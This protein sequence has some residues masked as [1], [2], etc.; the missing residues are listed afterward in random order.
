VIFLYFDYEDW[1]DLYY[2]EFH[3]GTDVVV[4]GVYHYDEK[5]L[6]VPDED[7][8][9]RK[10]AMNSIHDRAMSDVSGWRIQQ[11]EAGDDE[12]PGSALS[13]SIMLNG[14]SPYDTKAVQSFLL[15]LPFDERSH[16]LS[17]K[18]SDLM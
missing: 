15:S 7:E 5:L 13:M 11:L 2:I 12:K 4:M 1:C 14:I 18:I 17:M 10:E 8:E 3:P 9:K 16:L 6:P